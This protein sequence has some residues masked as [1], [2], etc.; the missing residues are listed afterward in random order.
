MLSPSPLLTVYGL[1]ITDSDIL[2]SKW[3]YYGVVQCTIFQSTLMCFKTLLLI[4]C[5]D[6][7]S[8]YINLVEWLLCVALAL[9]SL[10]LS[11]LSL[12]LLSIQYL[13][14]IY[15]EMFVRTH[16]ADAHLHITTV[17]SIIM[18]RS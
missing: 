2:E 11:I 5:S 3:L 16:F 10:L 15:G 7:K 14:R 12:I 9:L 4:Q 18:R 8:G 13:S 6:L 17:W 1:C